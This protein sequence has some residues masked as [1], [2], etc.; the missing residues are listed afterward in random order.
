MSAISLASN[1]SGLSG[2]V[3]GAVLVRV[4]LK[5]SVGLVVDAVGI[6]G[7]ALV[8]SGLTSR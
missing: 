4:G 7:A 6:N 3:V 1:E 5:R 2:G 8:S